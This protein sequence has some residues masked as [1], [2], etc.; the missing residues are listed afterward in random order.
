M[1]IQGIMKKAAESTLMRML[2]GRLFE[3]PSIWPVSACLL[4]SCR[5]FAS[6]QRAAPRSAAE[7][8]IMQHPGADLW[9]FLF[10]S[11]DG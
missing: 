8:C 1:S 10:S 7:C 3:A 4:T 11:P 2:G 5:A 6:G 9:C